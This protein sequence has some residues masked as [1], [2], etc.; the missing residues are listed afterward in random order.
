DVGEGREMGFAL[1][2][3]ACMNCE[4]VLPEHGMLPE[5]GIEQ[6]GRSYRGHEFCTTAGRK[7]AELFMQGT[8]YVKVE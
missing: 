4:G 6:R 8:F 1:A 3:I 5:I 7:R 2:E